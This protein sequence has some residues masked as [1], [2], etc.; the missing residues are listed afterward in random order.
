MASHVPVGRHDVD[1]LERR[2]EEQRGH[3]GSC[4]AGLRQSMRDEFDV[5][6]RMKD[7]VHAQ[8]RAFYGVAAGVALFIG[9]L[10]ARLLKI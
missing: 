5:R 6:S 7:S 1:E 10:F 8:P 2:A 9:Y 3:L 4:V